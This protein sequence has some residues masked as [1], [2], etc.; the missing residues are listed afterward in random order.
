MTKPVISLSVTGL[1]LSINFPLSCHDGWIPNLLFASRIHQFYLRNL[2]ALFSAFCN[3]LTDHSRIAHT[4]TFQYVPL[5]N[6]RAPHTLT[7]TCTPCH[8][9]VPLTLS[10]PRVSSH[11]QVP[12]TLS[13]PRVSSHIQVPL[14]LSHPRVSSHT[15]V[16]LTLSHPRVSFHI[17]VP[18]TLSHSR[19]LYSHTEW[20]LSFIFEMYHIPYGVKTCWSLTH[21]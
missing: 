10:H 13:H 21:F 11:I 14:T 18:L 9:Q 12:L 1:Y 3:Q 17:Q 6:S 19:I 8:I 20:N 4:I 16:P 2:T 15:Q 5:S 7:F